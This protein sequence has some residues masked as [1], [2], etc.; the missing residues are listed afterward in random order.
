MREDASKLDL[1][2]GCACGVAGLHARG[3]CGR[4]YA[5]WRRSE[6]FYGGLRDRV[7]ARDGHCCRSCGDLRDRALIVHHRRPGLS[8]MALLIT[9]CR[10]CH[11]RVHQTHRPSFAFPGVLRGLWRE[12]YP[13]QA[14]QLE[15]AFTGEIP[16]PVVN[17]FEQASLFDWA[18]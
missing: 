13:F 12:L 2:T 17:R 1:F 8:R 7:L 5:R 10:R 15:L 11:L 14:L 9:L 3:R 6:R 16:A 4:C 18:A